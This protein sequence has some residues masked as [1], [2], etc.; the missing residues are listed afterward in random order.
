MF[1]IDTF[2]V[3][4]KGKWSNKKIIKKRTI[5]TIFGRVPGLHIFNTFSSWHADTENLI[6]QFVYTVI[7]D[8]TLWGTRHD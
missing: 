2:P 4:M 8:P 7:V 1:H 3:G 5:K 6:F